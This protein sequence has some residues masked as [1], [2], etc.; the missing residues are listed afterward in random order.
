[1]NVGDLLNHVRM[2]LVK[3]GLSIPFESLLI[4]YLDNAYKSFVNGM[5]GVPDEETV[6]LLVGDTELVLPGYVL[7]V[8]SAERS[9]GET[10]EVVNRSDTRN[11]QKHIDFTRQGDVR[12]LMIGTKPNIAKVAY[13]P[14]VNTTLHL[15]V[16]RL[17]KTS[18]NDKND[19]VDD[20]GD[21]WQLSLVDG[22]MAM[23]LKNELDP[24]LAKKG[25]SFE[26]DFTVAFT[27]ARSEKTRAKSKVTRVVSYGGL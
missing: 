19:A 22:V 17:P 24:V 23:L 20:V 18:L 8:K 7:K 12:Y 10:V 16:D 26:A 1:M 14:Q 15:D 6:N 4:S 2:R 27:K 25:E 21:V 3:L 5:Q 11:S 9:D 13:I